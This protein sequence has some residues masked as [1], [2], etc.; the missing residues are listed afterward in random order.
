MEPKGG[1]YDAA[2][3]GDEFDDL[4]EDEEALSEHDAT[5]ENITV[6]NK[7]E[8]EVQ[9]RRPRGRPSNSNRKHGEILTGKGKT[10]KVREA[11]VTRR[12]PEDPKTTSGL[13]KK[14]LKVRAFLGSDPIT[15][16]VTKDPVI[17]RRGELRRERESFKKKSPKSSQQK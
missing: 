13:K 1:R 6:G 7:G 9:G 5:M 17:S 4:P 3:E 11:R 10:S 8:E 16:L 15:D 12:N 2:E 14:L